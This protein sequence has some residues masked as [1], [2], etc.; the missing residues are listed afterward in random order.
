MKMH[1][2]ATVGAWLLVAA[3]ALQR[4]ALLQTFETHLRARSLLGDK[5]LSL[6]EEKYHRVRALLAPR[7]PKGGKSGGGSSSGSSGDSSGSDDESSSSGSG[8]GGSNCNSVPL[9]SATLSSVPIPTATGLP[10]S[11]CLANE[12]NCI[13]ACIPNDATCCTGSDISVYCKASDRCAESTLVDNYFMCCPKDNQFCDGDDFVN[14]TFTEIGEF[15]FSTS[16]S[17]LTSG[18][19]S[20]SSGLGG[21]CASASGAVRV[22]VWGASFMRGLLVLGF[23]GLVAVGL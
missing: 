18:G 7:A 8:G 5:A 6:G 19:D 15:R 22:E 2:V 20:S 1:S 11:T 23:V 4:D 12:T 21:S 9:A 14:A 13:D 3:H 17:N 16:F 10:K